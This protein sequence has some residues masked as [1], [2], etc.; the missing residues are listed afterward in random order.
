MARQHPVTAIVLAS[1]AG[2]TV[3]AV[4]L[5]PPTSWLAPD[6]QPLALTL[7]AIWAAWRLL[8]LDRALAQRRAW[9]Q[10]PGWA[11]APEALA[12]ATTPAWWPAWLHRW[13]SRRG[14]HR[15]SCWGAPFAGRP[16]TRRC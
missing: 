12:S 14:G 5:A 11:L 1:V 13:R 6:M 9:H 8:A 3:L 15:G 7:S 10:A 16:G 2:S 4:A